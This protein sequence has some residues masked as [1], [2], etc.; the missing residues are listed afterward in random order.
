VA[1]AHLHAGVVRRS[2]GKSSVDAAAY[3]SRS[4]LI[5]ERTGQVYDYS[6]NRSDIIAS[7][8]MIP[9]DAPVKDMT[10]EQFWNLA[11]SRETR[12]NSR[13]ARTV[14]VA[15]PHEL[16]DQQREWLVRDYVRENFTR[17]GIVA[18]V[19]IHRAHTHGDERNIHAHIVLA[20]RQ[21]DAHGLG[22]KDRDLDRKETLEAW[23][24]KWEHLT[25]RHLERHGH[26]ARISMK[27]L[28]AQGIW[29][30]PQIHIGQA[31]S[32]LERNGIETDRGDQVRQIEADNQGRG[33]TEGRP[34]QT[35]LVPVEVES[36]VDRVRREF[37]EERAAAVKEAERDERRAG[38]KPDHAQRGIMAAIWK[39]TQ[40]A[41]VTLSHI[42]LGA[43]RAE[44]MRGR[45]IDFGFPTTRPEVSRPALSIPTVE[46]EPRA[47]VRGEGRDEAQADPEP[48][49]AI[50]SDR[51]RSWMAQS[52][53]AAALSDRLRVSA[54][55]S[56][57]EWA[58]KRGDKA[59][60]MSFERYV[61][62][63]QKQEAERAATSPE[64]EATAE[65]KAVHR[66]PLPQTNTPRLEPARS[67]V[68]RGSRSTPYRTMLGEL[69][70]NEREEL[71]DRAASQAHNVA[72]PQPAQMARAETWI[73][74][75]TREGRERGEVLRALVPTREQQRELAQDLDLEL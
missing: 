31:Q 22:A 21:M 51:A 46:K 49:P 7:W 62:Y 43:D 74:R 45:R 41:G 9:G 13:T 16:T 44:L 75:K 65:P 57:D 12:I 70:D 48:E 35:E 18:D 3:A 68:D 40:T 14:E 24:D 8:L 61:S 28:E 33:W 64:I 32:A 27:T 4:R 73:E 69:R 1:I 47:P 42:I 34:R 15:L 29:R 11:E 63:V 59:R 38:F 72:A 39:L 54:Q 2:A 50:A 26:E 71:L 52:G 58:A 23:R 60:S 19:S 25:N 17:K 30:E 5:D 37:L 55:K 66:Q 53:G 56:Y 20:T 67:F 6:R 36:A 10:R